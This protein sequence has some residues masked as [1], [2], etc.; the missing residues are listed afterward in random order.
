MLASGPRAVRLQK[1][2]IEDWEAMPVAAIQHGIDGFDAWASDEP[3][4]MMQDSCAGR[5][6]LCRRVKRLR[7]RLAEPDREDQQ[8]PG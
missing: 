3:R 6:D 5:A 1:A 8:S 2:L 4:E 7:G